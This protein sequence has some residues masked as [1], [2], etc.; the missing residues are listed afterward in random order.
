MLAGVAE[1]R[2]PGGNRGQA[3]LA[4]SALRLAVAGRKRDRQLKN[5]R[6]G[7]PCGIRTVCSP[8]CR[9]AARQAE[10]RDKPVSRHPHCGSLLQDGRRNHQ[11]KNCGQVCAAASL[12]LLAGV[13]EGRSPGEKPGASLSRGIRTAARFA[14]LKA[15]C[16]AKFREKLA[17]LVSVAR[18]AVAGCWQEPS[19][20]LVSRQ[21]GLR[22]IW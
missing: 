11:L 18:L 19:G 1:G 5:L 9:K 7:L 3:C 13:A 6:A 16:R 12:P 21:S 20:G 14:I 17:S 15:A 2:S 22:G 10:T 8:E 4:A